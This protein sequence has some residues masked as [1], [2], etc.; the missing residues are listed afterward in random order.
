MLMFPH[1]LKKKKPAVANSAGPD[2]TCLLF[3]LRR[4]IDDWNP[5]T[6][7]TSID[8]DG[9]LSE[10]VAT[11]H[12]PN[13][14][15]SLHVDHDLQLDAKKMAHAAR[16]SAHTYEAAQHVELRVPWDVPPFPTR[17]F[18]HSGDAIESVARTARYRLMFDA[19]VRESVYVL[20]T[21]HHADDQVETVLM[22]LGSGSSILG[23]GGM[24][25]LRRVGM[26]LGK[27]QNDFGW[28]GY[29]GLNRWIIRPLL[30]VPKVCC[31]CFP[32]F[33]WKR[34]GLTTRFVLGQDSCDLRVAWYSIC[35]R[36]N[37]L[38]A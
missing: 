10:A 12:L 32:F 20:A 37:K 6:T 24:R 36:P 13:S 7:S 26:A 4:M 8:R 23:L 2:S 27:V 30:D 14:I 19:M 38:P 22:R 28:F 18:A 16:I 15:L 3:L 5:R 11:D 17:P 25:P 29:E 1:L 35:A 9:D 31:W 34:K 21:G 33:F